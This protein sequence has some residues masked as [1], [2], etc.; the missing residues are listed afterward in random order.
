M[1]RTEMTMTEE[2]FAL[3]QIKTDITDGIGKQ[4]YNY[5][6]K[7]AKEWGVAVTNIAWLQNKP[8]PMQGALYQ[9]LKSRCDKE[10]LLVKEMRVKVVKRAE[11]NDKRAGFEGI[12]VLFNQRGFDEMMKGAGLDKISVELLREA[13]EIM[14]HTYHEEGWASLDTVK[15]PAMQNPDYL[16][17]MAA[18]RAIDRTM[19]MIVRCPFTA[20]SELSEGTPGEL[21]A[22]LPGMETPTPDTSTPTA[23]PGG[24]SEEKP[25]D[26]PKEGGASKPKGEKT[27]PQKPIKKIEEGASKPAKKDHKDEKVTAKQVNLATVQWESYC[28]T[29]AP[30]LE[31]P[32]IEAKRTR[33]LKALFGVEA[34][35][36]L[37]VAQLEELVGMMQRKEIDIVPDGATPPEKV[38]IKT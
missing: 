18:T 35:A 30:S 34:V 16:N 27:I 14:T 7:L 26:A 17:H 32:E 38:E 24:K 22:G 29:A 25:A 13:R 28:K 10:G 9:M 19:R 3:R 31:K 6:V 36:D 4:V 12:I 5:L 15:A 37:T 23:K 2:E 1:A 33:L 11:V 20:A 8:Y 21:I